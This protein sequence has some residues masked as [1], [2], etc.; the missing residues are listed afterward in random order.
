MKLLG[1]KTVA[2]L[3]LRSEESRSG[4]EFLSIEFDRVLAICVSALFLFILNIDFFLQ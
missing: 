3:Q 1:L 4:D 2:Q